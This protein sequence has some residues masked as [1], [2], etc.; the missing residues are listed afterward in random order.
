MFICS[1]DFAAFPRD[2]EIKGDDITYK[3]KYILLH[4][5]KKISNSLAQYGLYF[6]KSILVSKTLLIV[7]E[8]K[9]VLRYSMKHCITSYPLKPMTGTNT[10]SATSSEFGVT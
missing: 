3:V 9:F 6:Y 2:S 7:Q 1:W 4:F 8:H 5:Y 10:L